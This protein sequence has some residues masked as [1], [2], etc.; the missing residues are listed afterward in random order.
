MDVEGEGRQLST[1]DSWTLL[2]RNL[3]SRLDADAES[4]RPRH[5]SV[6]S[7]AEREALR[8]LLD[9]LSQGG[10]TEPDGPDPGDAGS[11]GGPVPEP[12]QPPV[13]YRIDRTVLELNGPHVSDWV[14]CVDFG[15][16]MSKAFACRTDSES[17]PDELELDDLD[18]LELPLGDADR[19]AGVAGPEG[20]VPMIRST[21][22][23]LRCGS[24][25]T[26]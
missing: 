4:E 7:D 1:A 11:P 17:A 23:F 6:V 18:L 13:E 12:V 10:I 22:W 14:L 3:L 8:A 26:G 5:R 2:L 9:Q 21:P 20:Y 24:T 15:T 25:M 16:A 19:R